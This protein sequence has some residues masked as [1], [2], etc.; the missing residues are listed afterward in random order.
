MLEL[1]L[2]AFEQRVDGAAGELGVDP[3]TR[4]TLNG[5]WE[6]AKTLEEE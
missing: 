4:A 2:D 5:W 6:Q 1:D 3:P